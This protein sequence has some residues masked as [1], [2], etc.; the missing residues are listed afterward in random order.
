MTDCSRLKDSEL[1]KISDKT[2]PKDKG[3]SPRMGALSYLAMIK[4]RNP[5]NSWIKP[6]L[7]LGSHKLKHRI[8]A[9]DHLEGSPETQKKKK[10][11]ERQGSICSCF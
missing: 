2:E 3:K 4:E 11:E 1:N 8:S 9:V 6:I 10:S 5:E 7:A